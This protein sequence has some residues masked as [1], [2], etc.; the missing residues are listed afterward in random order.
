MQTYQ[1]DVVVIGAGAIGS[2]IAREL[3][4]YDVDVMLIEKN[5]DVGG[6]ASKSNSAT[7][8]SGYDAPNGSLEAK[9]S[10]ASNA[11]FDQVTKELDVHF[12]RIGAI[13][14]AF[15]DED[16]KVLEAN[17]K[18]AIANGVFDV[19]ILS[20]EKVREME[21]MLSKD[22]K[23]GLLIPKESLVD[24]FEYMTALVENAV[25]NGVRLMTSTKAL[26][27][28]KEGG[29]V[30]SV[31]T[32]KGEIFAEYVINAAALYCD[33]LAETVGKCYFRNYP[34]KGEFFVL[35]K[36]LPYAPDHIIVPIPTPLTRGKLVTP[37]IE[38][39]LLIGPTAVNQEDKE[40]KSTTKEGL[41]S[42]LHDIRKM[43]P[44]VDPRD[45]VT[46]FAGLRP[47][48][49]P[50]EW[51]IKAF[52][53]L[54]GYIEV[55][56][57]TQGV[58]VSLATGVY[59]RE[60]LEEQGLKLKRKDDY[61][62]YRKSIKKFRE[63]SEEE[64]EAL[65]KQDSR[66]GNIICRC[67]TVTEAEIVEAIRRGAHS[68]DAIK[69]RLRAGMGRCQGGFCGPRVVEI[70]SRELGIQPEQVCKNEKGSEMLTGK[71]KP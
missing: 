31:L 13:Q 66:Y 50:A 47:A 43:L 45:S 11:M 35:D 9:L 48:R 71:N 52:D 24:V 30:R 4:K 28:R 68:V 36:Q 29:K 37:S 69:R 64:Q 60:L 49:D 22:I 57:I 27:I 7:I 70:L 38:G 34:R 55:N 40:D 8:V 51:S 15:T 19:E 63:C 61:N 65:V 2:A 41:D 44:Q 62:P 21:P 18:K 5:E 46:Q 3:S 39:N 42:I 17:K 20:G 10:V 12:R 32:D 56:G 6:D 26:E 53:D 25:D 14:V 33:E 58:S 67:E 1:T 59:V 23:A 54:K 16:V